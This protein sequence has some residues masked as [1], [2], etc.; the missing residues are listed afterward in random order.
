MIGKTFDMDSLEFGDVIFLDFDGRIDR[1]LIEDIN[2]SGTYNSRQYALREWGD[3]E[4]FY[5]SEVSLSNFIHNRLVHI[6]K[7]LIGLGLI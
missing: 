5:Y 2:F 3:R 7:P 6:K 4:A 1:L